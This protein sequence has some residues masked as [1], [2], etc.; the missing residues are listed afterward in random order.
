MVIDQ[1]NKCVLPLPSYENHNYVLVV[2]DSID[3]S[4]E[5]FKGIT[6]NKTE[7]SIENNFRTLQIIYGNYENFIYCFESNITIKTRE[8]ICPERPFKL[9]FDSSFKIGDFV[10]NASQKVNSKENGNYTWS[11]ITN[12]FLS[13]IVSNEGLNLNEFYRE[14]N[15]IDIKKITEFTTNSHWIMIGIS[16]G[17]GIIG[18]VFIGYLIIRIKLMKDRNVNLNRFRQEVAYETARELVR[19]IST[20]QFQPAIDIDEVD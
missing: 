13:K 16:V 7:C 5:H 6:W 3:C 20:P 12:R 15:A 1:R 9:R 18:V 2:K 11:D 19:S 4:E 10:F 8:F 17:I 14:I